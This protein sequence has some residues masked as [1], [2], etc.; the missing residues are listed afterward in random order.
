MKETTIKLDSIEA[1]KEFVALANACAFDIDLVSGRYAIDGK[2]IMGIFSLNLDKAVKA[3][4][5]SD[6]ADAEEF[7]DDIKKFTV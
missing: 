5:H 6:G 4:V 1:V 7:L 2:S 3:V